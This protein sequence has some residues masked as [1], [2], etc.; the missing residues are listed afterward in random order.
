MNELTVEEFIANR[1][2]YLKDG[3]ALEG[4]AAQKLARKKALQDKIDEFREEG[5]SYQEAEQKANEWI[6]DKAALH[7]PDQIAGGYPEKID[8]LGDLGI[9]SSLGSQW[10]NKIGELDKKIRDLAKNMT[11]EERKSTYLNI[12]LTE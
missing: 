8:G 7:N 4:D 6:K 5:L 3:R 1:D 2:R 9:N 12:K 10:K 11:E